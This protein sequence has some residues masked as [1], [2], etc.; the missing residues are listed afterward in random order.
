M[1]DQIKLLPEIKKLWVDALRSGLY[2]QG[3]NDLLDAEGGHCCL[4]VLV[5]ELGNGIIRPKDNAD[6]YCSVVLHDGETVD[7]GGGVL[8]REL[9]PQIYGQVDSNRSLQVHM[10]PSVKLRDADGYA[11]EYMLSELND[12]LKFTFNQIADVIEEQL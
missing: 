11:I 7:S 1:T 4:G 5:S 9:L 8:P 3:H 6:S 10:N 12:A 2:K